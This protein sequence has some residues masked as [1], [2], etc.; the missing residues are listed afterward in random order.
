MRVHDASVT[1]WVPDAC[2]LPTVHLPLRLAEF[3]QLFADSVR[4]LGRL[5]P[6][7]LRLYL[8]GAEQVE[9]TVRD[10]IAR[11]TQCCSFFTFTV[12][13]PEPDSLTL[14]VLVPTAHIPVLDA[15]ADCATAGRTRP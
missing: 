12:E 11:E 7:R 2:T 4:G 5:G 14:D 3:D 1:G 10:L 9:A 8:D 15:L 13:R 6:E